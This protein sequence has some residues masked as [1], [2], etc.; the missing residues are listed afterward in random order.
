[1]ST[2]RAAF[3]LGFVEL[4]P[5]LTELGEVEHREARERLRAAFV[6]STRHNPSPLAGGFNGSKPVDRPIISILAAHHR[7]T[8]PAQPGNGG[9]HGVRQ[10]TE[11]L[12]D[13]GNGSALGPLQHSDQLGPLCAGRWLI[14]TAHTARPHIG[15]PRTGF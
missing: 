10:P 13:L 8:G 5:Q 3:E 2:R 1:M 15:V 7:A 12:P 4:A 6:V 11:P 14:V 9:P